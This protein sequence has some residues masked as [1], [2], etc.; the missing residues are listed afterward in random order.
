VLGFILDIIVRV[1]DIKSKGD[2]KLKS[3][4]RMADFEI[5]CEMISRCLGYEDDDFIKAY[6]ENK[7]LGT[8]QVLE[9]SSVARV[10][11]HMIESEGTC[12]GTATILLSKLEEEAARLKIDIKK[13]KSWPKAA[14]I[15]SRRLNEI[16][17]NLEEL[18]IFIHTTQDPKTR[19][20]TIV[21]CKIPLEASEAS[22]SLDSRSKQTDI[23]NASAKA[24]KSENEI[25]PD[26][27][28]ENRGQNHGANARNATNAT[29]QTAMTGEKQEQTPDPSLAETTRLLNNLREEYVEYQCSKCQHK[30]L[31]WKN[32][33][34]PSS[35]PNC[36]ATLG[37]I[38][39]C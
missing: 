28:A 7:S 25:A 2:I 10:V 38:N 35:C 39:Q 24:T 36:K 1:L 33:P 18:N 20:R 3:I 37:G 21:I 5:A 16:K 19:L 13:D 4:S 31:L 14:H 12:S 6:E 15:L 27:N 17:A 29:L 30:E 22:E 8:S 9:G 23:A 11:I 34:R 32:S 26:N